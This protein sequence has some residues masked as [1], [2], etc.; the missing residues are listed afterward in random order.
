M[1][2]YLSELSLTEFHECISSLTI[3]KPNNFKSRITQVLRSEL[4]AELVGEVHE[5]SFAVWTYHYFWTS[6]IFPILYGRFEQSNQGTVLVIRRRMSEIGKVLVTVLGLLISY[7]IIQDDNSTMFLVRR[8]FA[9]SV[10]FSLFAALP[11]MIY[12]HVTKRLIE[13]LMAELKMKKYSK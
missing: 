10:L 3:Q 13:Y 2:Y 1:K 9:G 4:E 12:N 11:I 8:I 7:A 6:I 5:R